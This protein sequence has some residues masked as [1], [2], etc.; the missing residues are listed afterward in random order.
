LLNLHRSCKFGFDMKRD[1]SLPS[2]LADLGSKVRVLGLDGNDLGVHTVFEANQI[3]ERQ[4]GELFA[5]EPGANPP[6]CAVVQRRA[7]PGEAAGP[8]VDQG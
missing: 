4:G 2:G 5:V 1:Y 3:A 8:T 7:L 6:V